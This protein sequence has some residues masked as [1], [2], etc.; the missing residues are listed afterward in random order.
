MIN[1]AQRFTFEAMEA[2]PDYRKS[3]RCYKRLAETNIIN[4]QYK[5]AER[6]I[7]KLRKT[8]FYKDWATTAMECLNNE[9]KINK[10]KE[11]EKLRRYRFSND[12]LFDEREMDS[13]LGIL[14]THNYEN[15]MA[16]EYLLAYQLV[17]RDIAKFTNY[18]S[19]TR[20]S[21]YKYIPRSY[22]EAL[23]YTWTQSHKDF[24]G[25]PWEIS[26]YTMRNI[27]GFANI[28][29]S[30]NNVNEA[31]RNSYEN[32]YWYYLLCKK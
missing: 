7:N 28:Y 11:L 18:F 19:L 4:G 27:S 32:T 3:V 20:H 22:Q 30:G 31:L 17:Q 8:L 29:F 14:F 9:E 26:Q 23:V 25:I 5:V 12:F 15:K 1:S 21:N 13:M 10:H 24:N 6:Y 16:L 2:I